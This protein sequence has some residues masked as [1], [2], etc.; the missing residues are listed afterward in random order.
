MR[1]SSGCP[2][3][4]S[5]LEVLFISWSHQH[6]SASERYGA[7]SFTFDVDKINAPRPQEALLTSVEKRKVAKVDRRQVH[8]A[9]G[10]AAC[11]RANVPYFTGSSAARSVLLVA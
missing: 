1:K 11:W 5:V 2:H 3:I 4:E 10:E 8:L 6:K 7:E 9:T